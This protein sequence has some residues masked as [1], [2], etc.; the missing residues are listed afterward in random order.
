MPASPDDRFLIAGAV[1]S[2]H[3]DFDLRLDPDG[4]PFVG[5]VE[6]QVRKIRGPYHSPFASPHEAH[7]EVHF[8]YEAHE[9]DR[10]YFGVW[11]ARCNCGN[12][13]RST[14]CSKAIQKPGRSALRRDLRV[15]GG[16]I[17]GELTR[18]KLG[19]IFYNHVFKVRIETVTKGPQNEERPP[20]T[21]YSKV[22]ELWEKLAG[23]TVP[24][25]VSLSESWSP[26][27]SFSAPE[28]RKA[29]TASRQEVPEP[30]LQKNADAERAGNLLG[31]RPES[32]SQTPGS[33]NPQSSFQKLFLAAKTDPLVREAEELFGAEI[34]S[35]VS[36]RCPPNSN[37]NQP[38]RNLDV[39]VAK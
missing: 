12:A 35:V 28:V 23:S 27:L 31:P 10:K 2:N 24:L 16:R 13:R 15:A 11:R 4:K 5:F 21:H 22:S 19:R 36:L 26:S 20:A 25:S 9:G 34:C 30:K 8:Y 3:D 39:E 32:G 1:E 6:I 18:V 17:V 37:K 33:G 29:E 38:A 7:P 14:L